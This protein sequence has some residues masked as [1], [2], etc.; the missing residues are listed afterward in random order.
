METLI[1]GWIVQLEASWEKL[2]GG[3]ARIR[4][5]SADEA[6]G[7]AVRIF[8]KAGRNVTSAR[9]IY[10]ALRLNSLQPQALLCLNDFFRTGNKSG[11]ADEKLVYSAIALERARSGVRAAGQQFPDLEIAHLRL[12]WEMK[13]AIYEKDAAAMPTDFSDRTKFKIDELEY[14]NLVSREIQHIGS[15][16]K[17]FDVIHTLIGMRGGILEPKKYLFGRKTDPTALPEFGPSAAYYQWL[18]TE[19]RTLAA[20]KS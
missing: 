19:A 7:Y 11:K 15:A 18:R 8:K 6:A 3:P 16:D 1:W 5:L 14:V 13:L 17:A 9:F 10:H 12:L 20:Y 2:R 4:D